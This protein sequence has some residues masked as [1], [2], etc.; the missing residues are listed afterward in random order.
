M[1][2]VI[3]IYNFN[4][5]HSFLQHF[6]NIPLVKKLGTKKKYYNVSVSFDIETSSLYIDSNNNMTDDIECQKISN[7][8]IWQ[9]AINDNIIYGRYWS[10]FLELIN[11][12]AR[13]LNTSEYN[14]LIIYVHNLSY[15]FQYIYKMF[16]WSD[17]FAISERK[18]IYALTKNGIEFRCSYIL[19]GYNLDT[20]AKN[21]QNKK[22]KKLVGDLD[23][24]KVRHNET[25]LT[26]KELEY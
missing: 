25:E 5:K 14:R 8:Y 10:Q 16:N 11:D 19:S 12:I 21:L 1:E 20:L 2:V 6:N 15:E 23:Y 13:K 24:S 4:D 18:P 3:M 9:L 17:V 7:M 26:D 22:I